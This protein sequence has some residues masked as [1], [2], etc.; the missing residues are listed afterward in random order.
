MS[1]HNKNNSIDT[2]GELTATGVQFTCGHAIEA[3]NTVNMLEGTITSLF[4][5]V[6]KAFDMHFQHILYWLDDPAIYCKFALYVGLQKDSID[7]TS[8]EKEVFAIESSQWAFEEATNRRI[9]DGKAISEKPALYAAKAVLTLAA[10]S[11]MLRNDIH[12]FMPRI[13][14]SLCE[15]VG[16][17]AAV[18]FLAK[19]GSLESLSMWTPY[20]FQILGAEAALR[21]AKKSGGRLPKHGHIIYATEVMQFT[22]PEY[23]GKMAKILAG[24][25]ALAARH[26]YFGRDSWP[27]FGHALR[28]KVDEKAMQFAEDA[29]RRE[30]KLEEKERLR[31]NAKLEEK[32]RL[33][34]NPEDKL[35]SGTKTKPSETNLEKFE[36]MWEITL[37][38][39]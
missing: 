20:Q 7:L 21:R 8:Q 31:E 16:T 27:D 24:N 18:R 15:L 30:S 26:D 11:D 22:P 13:A 36:C 38:D 9:K 28:Q 14:P 2:D 32:E 1:D 25:C 10:E 34:E 3:A 17:E 29:A 4:K 23:R 5:H 33:R 6:R 39:E 12:R 37:A 19:A 35:E